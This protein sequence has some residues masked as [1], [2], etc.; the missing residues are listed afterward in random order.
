MLI[1]KKGKVASKQIT[2]WGG[3]SAEVAVWL[4]TQQP[5]AQ[6]VFFNLDYL[7]VALQGPKNKKIEVHLIQP[8]K[9]MPFKM[10][11]VSKNLTNIYRSCKA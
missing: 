3:G 8:P 10:A 1:R 2:S 6:S 4:L 11:I 9:L 5:R 7:T